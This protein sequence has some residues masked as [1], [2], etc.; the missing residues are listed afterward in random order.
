MVKKVDRHQLAKPA[1]KSAAKRPRV[2]A[3][4]RTT[5]TQSRVICIECG[6]EL[7]ISNLGAAERAIYCC[8]RVM[9]RKK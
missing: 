7:W 9:T 1:K 3:A 8:G 5:V 6:R 2:S 4:R